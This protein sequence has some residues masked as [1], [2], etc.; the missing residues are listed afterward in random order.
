MPLGCASRQPVRGRH[1]EFLLAPYP[2]L[3]LNTW[4][5]DTHNFI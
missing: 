5:M 2:P 4:T 1:G 3:T